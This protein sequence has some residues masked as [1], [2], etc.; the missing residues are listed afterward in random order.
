MN[1]IR[2]GRTFGG[3]IDRGTVYI[4]NGSKYAGQMYGVIKQKIKEKQL[5]DVKVDETLEKSGFFGK[6]RRYLT[7]TQGKFALAKIFATPNG[8]DQ[9]ISYIVAPAKGFKISNMKSFKELKDLLN[10]FQLDDLTMFSYAV[11]SAI[12]DAIKE[13][14]PSS[15]WK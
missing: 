4:P 5:D 12:D 8:T 3:D 9:Y 1:W 10:P 13:I 2:V 15:F 7:I 14:I 6:K 11:S